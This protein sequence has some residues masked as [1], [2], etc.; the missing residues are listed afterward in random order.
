MAVTHNWAGFTGTVDEV[1]EARR[2]GVSGGGRFRVASAT[3][4]AITANGSVNRTLNIAAGAASVCGLYDSTTAADTVAVAT[5]TGSVDRFDAIAAK[6]DWTT[7]TVQFAVI[8]GSSTG[9]PVVNVSTTTVNNAQINRIPGVR[10]DALLAVIRV[11]PSVTIIAPADVYDSRLYGAWSNLQTPNAT[12]RTS[13]D[14]ETGGVV[15]EAGTLATWQNYGGATGWL[16]A[17]GGPP[18]MG[19]MWRTSGFSATLG[20]GTYVWAANAGRV[21]PGWTM[22]TSGTASSGLTLP[23]DGFYEVSVRS[24]TS[25]GASTGVATT[26]AARSRSG[27]A[28]APV[29]AVVDHKF[30]TLDC[31]TGAV[32]I[33]P[34]KAGDL[35]QMRFDVNSGTVNY[36]GVSEANS[37]FMHARWVGPL[38]GV[39]PV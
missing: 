36:V 12:Y 27:A 21:S 5:N 31:S 39:T 10:Y 3:D 17:P 22:D 1:A 38:N 14:V 19:K 24:I 35:L 2:F 18:Y 28:S 30:D 32:A 34:L 13:M 16:P 26:S 37:G 11:R 7:H 29:V 6:F 20:V 23:F 33:V 25:G 8:Q 15:A 4:W 9:P